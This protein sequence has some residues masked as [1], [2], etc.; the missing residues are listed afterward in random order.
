M[1]ILNNLTYLNV[2]RNK[3]KNFS[4]FTV[5]EAFPNLKWLDVSY[6]KILELPAF[7]VPKLEYLDITGNK[8]EKINEAWTGHDNIRILV[9][10]DNKFKNLAPFKNMKKLE[11]LYMNSNSITTLNGWESLPALKVLHLR[12]N[13]IDKIDEELPELPEL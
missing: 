3:I 5:E 9:S 6:N 4:I 7:K 10:A 11:E 1:E 8:L 2:S 13:K 12:R